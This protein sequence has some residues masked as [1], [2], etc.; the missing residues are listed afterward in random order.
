MPKG[1]VQG[2]EASTER[3]NTP[4]HVDTLHSS[5][6]RALWSCGDDDL[7][8]WLKKTIVSNIYVYM[9][10]VCCAC[11]A[12]FVLFV[13]CF[14]FFVASSFN[15]PNKIQLPTLPSTYHNFSTLHE[16][17]VARLTSY[18][19]QNSLTNKIQRMQAPRPSHQHTQPP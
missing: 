12:L 19:G 2:G 7:I 6:V 8:V 11:C 1:A 3:I 18:Q 17:L 5:R 13:L 14:C 9:Y 15:F 16:M 10:I 4:L